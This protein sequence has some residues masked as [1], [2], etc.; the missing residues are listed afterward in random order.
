[1]LVEVTQLQKASQLFSFCGL[2]STA[3]I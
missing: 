1:L 3:V 2:E